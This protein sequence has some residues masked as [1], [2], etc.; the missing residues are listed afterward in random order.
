V[1]VR[2]SFAGVQLVSRRLAGTRVPP[3]PWF[4]VGVGMVVV[5]VLLAVAEIVSVLSY[6]RLPVDGVAAGLALLVVGFA[7]ASAAWH[8][9]DEPDAT[10]FRIGEDPSADVTAAVPGAPGQPHVDVLRRRGDGFELVLLPGMTGWVGAPDDRRT[11][12]EL[13]AQL[14]EGGAA[15]PDADG[16]LR[17]ALSPTDEAE[18]VLGD[19]TLQVSP[20]GDIEGPPRASLVDLRFVAATAMATLLVGGTI[21]LAMHFVPDAKTL[22]DQEDRP[23]VYP[24]R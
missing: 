15:E 18:V 11:I 20:A 13:V 12:A 22:P 19:L 1:E 5:G 23:V 6:A 10:R 24:Q 14:M 8:R 4:R 21:V 2:A 16:R 9:A 17:V 7:V 3:G